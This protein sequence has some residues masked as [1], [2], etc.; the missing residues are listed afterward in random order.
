MKR[1]IAML[2][3]LVMTASALLGTVAYGAE[4]TEEKTRLVFLRAGTE[5]ERR[6]Y[7][8]GL[9]ERF[10]AENPDIEIEYQE[11]PWGDDFETKLNTGFA[12]GT[13]PDVI[14][15]SMASM[16]TRVPLGQ[17]A[18]LDAYAE[19]WEGRE[20][21][22]ENALKLGSVGD[23][24]YGIA[25]F[26]DPRML[27]YNKELFQEA[28]LDP[29]NPPA[30]WEELMTAHLA[31]VKKDGDQV[32]QTGFAMPTSGSALH[33]Y[34]SIFIEQNGVKNLV[35]EENDT[36]LVNTPEAI[37]AAEF[38][39]EIRDAGTIP[40]DCSTVDQNPFSMGLA[41]MTMGND[42]DFQNMNQG[43]LE[44][45]IALAPPLTGKVQATFCGV[46]FLF[47][48]GETK[49]PDEAWRF[50]EYISEG[51]EMWNRYE[52]I[53]ATPLR[54]SLKEEFIARD[55]EKNSVIYEAI[56]CGTGSPKVAYSNSVY[57]IVSSALEEIMYDVKTPEEAM[58]DA[59][60]EIQ[61]EID[62]Q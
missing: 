38:M 61:S 37:Q 62:N 7:W 17:Y 45:K 56:N 55:P 54:E 12:S 3:A 4:G 28:G 6:D 21:F 9:V 36:V 14:C 22:M 1:R 30:T 8:N 59:A 31:L 26:P 15:F 35:D 16:G 43:E 33:Q 10:E 19:N 60:G 18:A 41:A 32:V 2:T 49:A 50:M 53:G 48:S 44:G 29:E 13:A 11:A 40:W 47:M 24:L 42:Q 52:E 27:I 57:N 5:P 51:E 25:V 20:D 58:N 23:H 46:T 39:K 34:Y